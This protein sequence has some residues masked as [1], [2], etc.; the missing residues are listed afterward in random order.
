MSR[1]A[2]I[3]QLKGVD[4]KRVK[5]VVDSAKNDRY[6]NEASMRD[7]IGLCHGSEVS[8]EEFDSVMMKASATP[9]SESYIYLAVTYPR[10]NTFKQF[11]L[12]FASDRNDPSS[13]VSQEIVRTAIKNLFVK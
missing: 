12:A 8:E 2:F 6:Y 13:R 10:L 4:P 11:F 5:A 7:L 3:E 1:F 9:P